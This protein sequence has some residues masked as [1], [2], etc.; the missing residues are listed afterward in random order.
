MK[1]QL[2]IL[3][4]RELS[5]IFS[6]KEELELFFSILEMLERLWLKLSEM[7]LRKSESSKEKLL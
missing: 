4:M 6:D 2:F 3:L 1:D 7:L 5:V